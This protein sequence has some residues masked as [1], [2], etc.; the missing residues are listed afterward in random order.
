MI[1]GFDIQTRDIPPY[2]TPTP[3]KMSSPMLNLYA[4]SLFSSSIKK[5]NL[6]SLSAANV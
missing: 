3:T 5:K 2:P 4:C 1:T 6:K